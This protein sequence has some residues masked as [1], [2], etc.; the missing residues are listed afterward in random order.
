MNKKIVSLPLAVILAGT[1]FGCTAN[2]SPTATPSFSPNTAVTS[3]SPAPSEIP[4]PVGDTQ[5]DS[6]EESLSQLSIH[7]TDTLSN[8]DFRNSLAE[9]INTGKLPN[10]HQKLY[11]DMNNLVAKDAVWNKEKAAYLKAAKEDSGFS[12]GGKDTDLLLSALVVHNTLAVEL[13]DSTEKPEYQIDSKSLI[14]KDGALTW[15]Q[16]GGLRVIDA[17]GVITGLSIPKN[18]Q[19]FT[20]DGSMLSAKGVLTEL[21][22]TR[23]DVGNA[24]AM[25]GFLKDAQLWIDSNAEKLEAET[26]LSGFIEQ[27]FA[28]TEIEHNATISISGTVADYAITL[29][30]ENGTSTSISSGGDT[31]YNSAMSEYKLEQSKLGTAW[32]TYETMY[33]MEGSELEGEKALESIVRAATKSEAVKGAKWS[34]GSSKDGSHYAQVSFDGQ[35]HKFYDITAIAG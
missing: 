13:L 20:E 9:F 15:S 7:A 27:I 28:E 16:D 29:E 17:N 18:N 22:K 21:I 25:K 1:L 30:S 11:A 3:I 10:G 5:P 14:K 23:S 2:G 33:L 26:D 19:Y 31:S 8:D 6:L 35:T 4:D 12:T 34:V 32:D 24:I